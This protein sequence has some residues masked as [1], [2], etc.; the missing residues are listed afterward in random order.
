MVQTNQLRSRNTAILRAR[1]LRRAPTPPEYRLWQMLRQ[2]LG[3]FKFRRRHPLGH[4]TLD[5]FCPTTKLVIEMD[6]DSHGMGDNPGR[7]ERRDA[8]LR[9]QGCSLS[10]S[11]LPM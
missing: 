6:G 3:G 7:D 4:Y 10:G 2:R 5:F 1:E 9:E 11:M 8:W